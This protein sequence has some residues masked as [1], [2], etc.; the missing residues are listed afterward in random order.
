MAESDEEQVIWDAP[1]DEQIEGDGSGLIFQRRNLFVEP[2]QVL[3]PLRPIGMLRAQPRHDDLAGSKGIPCLRSLFQL[4]VGATDVPVGKRQVVL[5]AG[6][7]SVELCQALPYGK[8]G[9][10]G[11]ERSLKRVL[12][13]LRVADPFVSCR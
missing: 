10:V 4:Q 5:P 13:R 6:I 2:S 3:L 8:A 7:G 1:A 12:R 11:G 9:L